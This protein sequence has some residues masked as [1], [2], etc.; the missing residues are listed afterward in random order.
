M[1]PHTTAGRNNKQPPVAMA[2][3]P[4]RANKTPRHLSRSHPHS[5]NPLSLSFHP[6]TRLSFHAAC[7][8]FSS[9]AAPRSSSFHLYLCTPP[10]TYTHPLV[11]SYS[12][13]RGTLAF[14]LPHST[15]GPLYALAGLLDG[16]VAR[17]VTCVH[18]PNDKPVLELH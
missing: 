11:R 13:L 10:S 2:T 1:P 8:S 4:S 14:S 16:F 15:S 3:R 9:I 18:E 12:P 5:F 17:A 7:L 6:P